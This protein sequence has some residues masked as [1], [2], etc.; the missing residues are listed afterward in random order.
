[1]V[2]VDRYTKMAEFFPCSSTITSKATANLFLQEV[3]SRHSLPKEV[4]YDRGPQFISRFW[5]QFLKG[6]SIKP[7]RSS[8]YH[9]QSDGQTEQINQI[10]EQYL[11]C[12]V[13]SRQD[14]W[15]AHL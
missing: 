15:V 4:I 13:P 8:G 3:F 2:V 5:S 1:M 12:F 14:T 10:L 6:L 9:P 11:Q 7:C